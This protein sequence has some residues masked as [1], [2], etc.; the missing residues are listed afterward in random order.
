MLIPG[1]LNCIPTPLVTCRYH[2]HMPF[3]RAIKRSGHVLSTA[4]NTQ[5]WETAKYVL[6][7]NSCY[8]YNVECHLGS[9]KMHDISEFVLYDEK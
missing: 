3:G 7:S 5:G 8:K 1:P 6:Y 9:M 2:F 4:V